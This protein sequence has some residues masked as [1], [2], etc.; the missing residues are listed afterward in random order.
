MK[1]TYLFL[2][3]F[4]ASISL[5]AQNTTGSNNIIPRSGVYANFLGD[6]SVVSINYERIFPFSS[7]MFLTGKV[8]V[9][10]NEDYHLHIAEWGN[11]NYSPDKFIT[12]THHITA[13]LGK[14]KFYFEL[15]L[16]G[17][18]VGGNTK[19]NYLL[20]PII[21]YRLQPLKSNKVNFR[22]FSC[23]PIAPFRYTSIWFSPIGVSVGLSL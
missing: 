9:G 6:A 18:I 20:Y 4:F 17:T 8:G 3:C 14:K 12:F 5:V 15:G 10:Y 1:K 7:T 19:Y 21:G 11:S 23:V 2:L 22:V 16:G 13:N